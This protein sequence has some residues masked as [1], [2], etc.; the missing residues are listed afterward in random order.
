MIKIE[1]V[2]VLRNSRVWK[3]PGTHPCWS[4][5][6]QKEP[7]AAR[8]CRFQAFPPSSE[9]DG[10]SCLR[11]SVVNRIAHDLPALYVRNTNQITKWFSVYSCT[12]FRPWETIFGSFN[13]V[14]V[15]FF[16]VLCCYFMLSVLCVLRKLV[17]STTSGTW[18]GWSLCFNW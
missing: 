2:F 18:R 14:S 12:R 17:P 5:A 3:T 6:T 13:L 7:A 10:A 1:K 9:S 11:R 8:R 15:R 16:F 4:G